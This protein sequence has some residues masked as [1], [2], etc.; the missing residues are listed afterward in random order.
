VKGSAPESSETNFALAPSRSPVDLPTNL[1]AQQ[2]SPD[3]IQCANL[4]EF[5]CTL[6]PSQVH[7]RA[8]GLICLNVSMGAIELTMPFKDTMTIKAFLVGVIFFFFAQQSESIASHIALSRRTIPL[9]ERYPQPLFC[10]GSYV[11]FLAFL[12][13]SCTVVH[14]SRARS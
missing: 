13:T 1:Y 9:T 7:I 6:T 10:H 14:S 8:S 3:R 4:R 11:M 2:P 12:V 5:C